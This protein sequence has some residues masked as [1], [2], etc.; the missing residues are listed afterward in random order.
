MPLTD[1]DGLVVVPG[2]VGLVRAPKSRVEVLS[3]KARVAVSI[4][5]TIC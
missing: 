4:L 5:V 2:F 1:D 3:L